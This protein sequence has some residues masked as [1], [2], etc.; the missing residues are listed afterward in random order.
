MVKE[1]LICPLA[2]RTQVVTIPTMNLNRRSF[3]SAAASVATVGGSTMAASDK[4]AIG[5]T[6]NAVKI[7]MVREGDD[8]SD[9]FKVSRDA[10]F[11]GVSLLYPATDLTI[12]TATKAFDLTGL[13]IH[14][15]NN[16]EHWK[17][18]LSDPDPSVRKKAFESVKGT[19][20]FASDVG[21]SSILLVVGKVTDPQHENHD[22]V[23]NRSTTIIKQLIPIAARLGVRI[24][25]ENVGNGFCETPEQWARY[26]DQFQSP[27]VGAF[28]DIGNH[29]SRGGAD[30]WARVLGS[31]IVKLDLKGHD[32]GTA[33]N[34]N[35]YEGDV[36]WGNVRNELSAIR[37]TGWVT[38]ETKGG[39]LERLKQ[40]VQ[41][42][43]KAMGKPAV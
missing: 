27:W 5:P 10:G 41:R 9:K 39:G 1:G 12:R 40:V 18:R 21:A 7:T 42:M 43:N 8:L 28:Y 33:K 2:E 36:P 19:I 38:A 17:I 34:C 25:V 23:W 20:Q 29:H 37:F 15:V 6:W 26:I 32:T 24:L 31:R 14:N 3:L 35:M 30:N 16:S 13:P 4:G 22:H 11:D